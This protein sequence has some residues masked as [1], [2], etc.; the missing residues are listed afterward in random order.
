MRKYHINSE[1]VVGQCR[2]TTEEGCPFGGADA[3]Y[4]S[5]E[6]ARKAYEVSMSNAALPSKKRG[7]K[8]EQLMDTPTDE[9]YTA[10]YEEITNRK[11]WEIQG[12]PR[13]NDLT[14]WGPNHTVANTNK[15]RA[16][17]KSFI[18]EH[19]TLKD[20]VKRVA[21]E[22]AALSAYG[23]SYK[24]GTETPEVAAEF[25]AI[26]NDESHYYGEK[27]LKKRLV[28]LG[29]SKEDMLAGRITPSQ[30]IGRGYRNPKATALEYFE[31]QEGQ[32]REAIA[33]RGRSVTL[34]VL[35]VRKTL[36]RRELVEA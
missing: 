13:W 31:V 32:I 18:D 24:A 2:A 1:G 5:P 35:D 22:K 27:A 28:E 25:E 33:T 14:S 11:A 4:S 19:E 26:W 20:E 9:D 7:Q 21:L 16:A 36:R 8:L 15:F 29:A 10:A 12:F 17:C 6:G 30:V 3:H 34:N 23:R